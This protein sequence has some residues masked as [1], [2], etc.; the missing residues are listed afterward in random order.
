MTFLDTLQRA[1]SPLG[2]PMP[3]MV[4]AVSGGADSVALV[5][6]LLTLRGKDGPPLVVA[7]L[8]HLLRGPESDRDEQFVRDLVRG[9][10]P[11]HTGLF[12]ATDQRPI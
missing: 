8:N 9:L 6:G 11:E 3:G 1:C 12:Y 4:L 7:H 5:R 10:S 2:T